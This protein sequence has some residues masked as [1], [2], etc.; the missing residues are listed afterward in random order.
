MELQLRSYGNPWSGDEGLLYL[1]VCY[2]CVKLFACG[3]L[4]QQKV[5]PFLVEEMIWAM[6]IKEQSC[7]LSCCGC[8][9]LVH[10]CWCGLMGQHCPLGSLLSD[11]TRLAGLLF[12]IMLQLLHHFFTLKVKR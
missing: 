1:C 9:N 4:L 8:S 11:W 7:N 5:V 2:S 10:V 3:S 12:L 6:Y